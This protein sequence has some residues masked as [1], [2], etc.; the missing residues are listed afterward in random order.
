MQTDRQSATLAARPGFAPG[1]RQSFAA[2]GRPL[3]RDFGLF[4]LA[5]WGGAFALACLLSL[6]CAAA[7][8][9]AAFP[10]AAA[11]Y[12]IQAAFVVFTGSVC[13][14]GLLA[15][16]V[17]IWDKWRPKPPY[18]QQFAPLVHEHPQYV[19]DPDFAARKRWC[20]Q[21][22]MDIR[23][24]MGNAVG[25]VERQIDH[26]RNAIGTQN[27]QVMARLTELDEK[28]E[29]R[30]SRIHGRIDP[31]AERISANR[32]AIDQHL[33]DERSKRVMGGQSNGG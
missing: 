12:E 5:R 22:R 7:A 17:T 23:K 16:L 10:G 24:E 26:L 21:E 29:A 4:S 28:Q 20:A 11:S 14:I 9:P 13:L 18:H 6:P 31:L 2:P 3:H 15:A 32:Q 30:A 33:S 19:R 1:A 25:K 27:E 8:A